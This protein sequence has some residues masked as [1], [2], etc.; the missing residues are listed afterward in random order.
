MKIKKYKEKK[1]TSIIFLTGLCLYVFLTTLSMS[2]Y[3]LLL[4]N[5]LTFG[6]YI[7]YML[8][9]TC[10]ISDL[11][12]NKKQLFVAIILSG[13]GVAVSYQT[14]DNQILCI[15]LVL[16]SSLRINIYHLLRLSIVTKV[17]SI[18]FVIISFLIGI[19]PD[20]T[21]T[22]LWQTR[23]RHSLGFS[24]N[25]NLSV[26]FLLI[27]VSY[28]IYKKN[29]LHIRD[30]FIISIINYVINVFTDSSTSYYLTYVALLVTLILRSKYFTRKKVIQNYILF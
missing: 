4:P 13:V 26:F 21:N 30:Y 20:S 14:R 22:R 27:I 5:I 17:I 6:R 9:L 16:L 11:H 7:C 15:L 24:Y 12:C 19:L 8:F 1:K 3:N 23:I 25:N 2:N 28:I 18:L 29:R 10:I